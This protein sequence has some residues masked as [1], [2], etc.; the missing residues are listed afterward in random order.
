MK[1]SRAKYN[2]SIDLS[3]NSRI[4]NNFTLRKNLEEIIGTE[5]KM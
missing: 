4:S 3:V 2:F 5:I 1:V